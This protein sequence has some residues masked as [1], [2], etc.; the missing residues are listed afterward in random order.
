MAAT[1]PSTRKQEAAGRQ[2]VAA[3]LRVRT[4]PALSCAGA[5]HLRVANDLRSLSLASIG[6][7]WGQAA[8]Q[9]RS[10]DS[11]PSECLCADAPAGAY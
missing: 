9:A 2:L 4:L 10:E 1:T 6:T 7:F 11:L 3:N 5:L 8:G